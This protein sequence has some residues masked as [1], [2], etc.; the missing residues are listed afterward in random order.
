MQYILQRHNDLNLKSL[1]Y[2][3]ITRFSK[4]RT[5]PLRSERSAGCLGRL[6]F[7]G[8]ACLA[9]KRSLIETHSKLVVYNQTIHNETQPYFL[10]RTT[11]C[12]SFVINPEIPVEPIATEAYLFVKTEPSQTEQP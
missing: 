10:E 11:V 2:K 4:R 8:E 6:R 1:F 12:S 5:V 9:L 3:Q 7:H